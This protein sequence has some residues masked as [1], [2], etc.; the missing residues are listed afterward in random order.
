MNMTPVGLDWR[1]LIRE[2]MLLLGIINVLQPVK[3]NDAFRRLPVD[4]D[5]KRLRRAA[6]ALRSQEMVMS[7]KGGKYVVT[8]RGRDILSKKPYARLRDTGRMWHLYE[9]TKGGRE[10]G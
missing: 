1:S 7:V 10:A 2:K 4:L 6:K 3:M 9:G 5:P 8:R